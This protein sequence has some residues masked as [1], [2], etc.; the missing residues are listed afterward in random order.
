M[1]RHSET[2][3]TTKTGKLAC[4]RGMFIRRSPAENL[5][6]SQTGH[7]SSPSAVTLCALALKHFNLYRGEQTYA[8]TFCPNLINTLV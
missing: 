8:A 6:I 2:K 7:R 1:A 3:H 5:R 4:A